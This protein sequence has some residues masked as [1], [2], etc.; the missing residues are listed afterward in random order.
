MA[1]QAPVNKPA[2]LHL[3]CTEGLAVIAL[4]VGGGTLGVQYWS[5][6]R[7]WWKPSLAVQRVPERTAGNVGDPD[8]EAIS[9]LFQVPADGPSW[10]SGPERAARL[11]N[12]RG[13]KTGRT[14]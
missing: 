3:P 4:G 6:E 11:P 9:G 13:G 1:K 2:Q 12:L 10:M 14:G 8:P 5:A 7:E